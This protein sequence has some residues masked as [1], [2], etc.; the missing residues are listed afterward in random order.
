MTWAYLD[1]GFPEHP[2]VI[3][4]GGEAAWLYVSGLCYV[5]RRLTGGVIHA[6]MIPRLTD[7]RNPGKLAQRLV[8]ARL[9][10][11]H[12]EGFVVHDYEQGNA[13]A[14]DAIAK[15]EQRKAL[16]SEHS[17]R[18]AEARWSNPQASSV[19]D[20]QGPSKQSSS[21]GHEQ[22]G[23]SDRASPE[24]ES[25]MD[26]ASNGHGVGIDGAPPSASAGHGTSD[27]MRARGRAYGPFP[28][29]LNQALCEPQA[30]ANADR[31]EL[32]D[33]EE[34]PGQDPPDPLL[35]RFAGLWPGRAR[36]RSEA[37]LVL[38][39]CRKHLDDSLIDECIG[40]LME[41]DKPA[42]QPVLLGHTLATWAEQRGILTAGHP[43]LAE[44]R[45]QPKA[46]T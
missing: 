12:A 14:L 37:A 22:E 15:R 5:Q 36:M 17:R 35:D 46:G 43:G 32:G 41:L 4:A 45:N 27:A 30:V 34:T 2:K 13:S 24:H 19:T 25:G 39:K 40:T 16:K 7:L 3:A 28:L 10:D 20:T 11:V 29:P 38:V 23:S 42:R 18:A 33:L 8:E 21:L 26:W 44:M 1:D 6:A 9:W 31:S